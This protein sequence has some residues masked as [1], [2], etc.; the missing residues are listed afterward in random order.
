[1]SGIVA[2]DDLDLFA[3]ALRA[4]APS[5]RCA[6][7]CRAATQLDER[8]RPT[9]RAAGPCP[10][11]ASARRDSRRS[12]RRRQPGQPIGLAVHQPPGRGVDRQRL[13]VRDAPARE[14][15]APERRFVDLASVLTNRSAICDALLQNA[16]PTGRPRSPA[17]RTRSPG[18]ASDEHDVG[19]VDP[20]MAGADAFGAA[21][22]DGTALVIRTESW[23][24]EHGAMRPRQRRGMRLS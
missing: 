1:M 8:L 17:T 22:T 9:A 4:G 11:S 13:A 10:A 3:E 5:D 12:D 21:A 19:A 16:Q 2:V 6:R 15:L 23:G 24:D 7:G 18:S 14:A 20:R